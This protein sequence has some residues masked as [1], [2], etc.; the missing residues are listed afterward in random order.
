MSFFAIFALDFFPFFYTELT[1]KRVMEMRNDVTVTNN[2]LNMTFKYCIN[3]DNVAK[4]CMLDY[5][6]HKININDTFLFIYLF[7]YFNDRTL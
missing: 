5:L 2:S 6:S 3:E 1:Q 4:R 7:I